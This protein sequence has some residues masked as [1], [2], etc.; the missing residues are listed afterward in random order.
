MVES[1]RSA[2]A[3][4]RAAA[5]AIVLTAVVLGVAIAIH[6]ALGRKIHWDTVAMVAFAGAAGLTAINRF[7]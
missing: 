3:W 2:I 4:V 6:L 7:A 1:D 5:G